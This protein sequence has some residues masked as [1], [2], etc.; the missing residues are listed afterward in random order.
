MLSGVLCKNV[1]LL[2]TS[3]GLPLALVL[4]PTLSMAVIVIVAILIP[5]FSVFSSEP[6]SMGTLPQCD[7]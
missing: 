4:V 1:T 6:F 7:S 5:Y 2:R 3:P